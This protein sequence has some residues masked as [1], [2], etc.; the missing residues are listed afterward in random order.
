VRHFRALAPS[1]VAASLAGG[2]L[3]G[4]AFAAPVGSKANPVKAKAAKVKGFNPNPLVVKPGAL[5]WFRSIDRKPHNAQARR[6]VRGK[7]LFASSPAVSTA[8]F[9]VRAPRAV[10]SYPYFCIV[11]SDIQKGVLIVRK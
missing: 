6:M 2:L 5:I 3:A 7:P 1:L 10:G 11:H 4:A 8:L 9:S